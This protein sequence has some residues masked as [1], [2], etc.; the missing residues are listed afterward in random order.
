MRLA[1][2]GD[3]GAMSGEHPIEREAREATKAMEEGRYDLFLQ[4]IEPDSEVGKN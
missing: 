4:G 2:R 1:A 3:L